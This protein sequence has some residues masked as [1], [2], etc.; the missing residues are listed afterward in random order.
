MIEE[1]KKL[2]AG[3]IAW[4]TVDERIDT[5]ARYA[6]RNVSPDKLLEML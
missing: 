3:L 5:R 2:R 6:T 1:A 4:K